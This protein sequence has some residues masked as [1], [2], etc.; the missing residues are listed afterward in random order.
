MMSDNDI[1]L[2]LTHWLIQKINY[3]WAIVYIEGLQLMIVFDLSNSVYP[4]GNL[5]FG[6]S[7]FAKALWVTGFIS[8]LNMGLN[9]SMLEIL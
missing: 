7:F 1:H 8:G 3:G 9:F 6:S 2:I 5:Y 4:R